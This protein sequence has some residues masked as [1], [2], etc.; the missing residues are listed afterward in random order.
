MSNNFGST[1][2]ATLY[3]CKFFNLELSKHCVSLVALKTGSSFWQLQLCWSSSLDDMFF[4]SDSCLLDSGLAKSV[5]VQVPRGTSSHATLVI[6]NGGLQTAAQ[7]GDHVLRTVIRVP[8]KL[9]WR[10]WR[11]A[12]RY[13]SLE[14]VDI[15]TVDGLEAEMDHKFKVNVVEPDKK[16]NSVLERLTVQEPQLSWSDQIRQRLGMTI[17][18][19]FKAI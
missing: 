17:Q 14:Q 19:D 3:E 4:S 1:G 10:Q 12:R 11:L 18:K 6:S 7:V 13:A 15:G 8:Q 5:D 2:S 16:L 9:S